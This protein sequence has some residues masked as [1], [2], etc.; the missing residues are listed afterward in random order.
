MTECKDTISGTRVS[1]LHLAI[2]LR[3]LSRIGESSHRINHLVLSEHRNTIFDS[4]ICK[5]SID[6][7]L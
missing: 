3:N 2:K 4:E 7:Y 5:D 6:Q 1:L